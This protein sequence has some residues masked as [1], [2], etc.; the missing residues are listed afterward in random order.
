MISLSQKCPLFQ[1]RPLEILFNIMLLG[2]EMKSFGH[3]GIWLMKNHALDVKKGCSFSQGVKK[4]N[5]VTDISQANDFAPRLVSNMNCSDHSTWS[6][7]K[8]NLIFEPQ[9]QMRNRIH[10]SWIRFNE[11]LVKHIVIKINLKWPL[12]WIWIGSAI[13][14]T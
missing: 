6:A 9:A 1:G 13:L 4:N 7:K 10:M 12:K 2:V 8:R 5:Y 14:R 11:F 3:V